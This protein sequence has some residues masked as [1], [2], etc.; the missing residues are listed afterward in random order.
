MYEYIDS[1][2]PEYEQ[3]VWAFVPSVGIDLSGRVPVLDW[4]SQRLMKPISI[5]L[6]I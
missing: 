4:H 3:T 6:L 5:A 2:R 1:E